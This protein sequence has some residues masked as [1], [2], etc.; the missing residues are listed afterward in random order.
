MAKDPGPIRPS[1]S[2][3]AGSEPCKQKKNIMDVSRR[4]WLT[5]NAKARQ[6]IP[7]RTLPVSGK[8]VTILNTKSSQQKAYCFKHL[9]YSLDK[10]EAQKKEARS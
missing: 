6:N 3:E 1:K 5:G 8:T 2:T 4:D 7:S 9:I 10:E